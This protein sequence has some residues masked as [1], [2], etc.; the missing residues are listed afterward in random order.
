VLGAVG[1]LEGLIILAFAV[2]FFGG[3]A[4]AFF[5]RLARPCREA[6]RGR[7]DRQQRET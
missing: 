3:V 4:V 2:G 5:L 7:P 6:G 1:I